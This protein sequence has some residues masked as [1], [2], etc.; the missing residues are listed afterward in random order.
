M[1]DNSNENFFEGYGQDGQDAAA[2]V[3]GETGENDQLQG[4]GAGGEA[5]L[6]DSVSILIPRRL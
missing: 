6:E 3:G 1:A 5:M 2:G 4:D